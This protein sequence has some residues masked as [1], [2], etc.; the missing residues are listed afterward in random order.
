MNTKL[1]WV[2][3]LAEK[4]LTLEYRDGGVTH[5]SAT[6]DTGR[7]ILSETVTAFIEYDA[8]LQRTG[9]A[10]QLIHANQVFC[11][12]PGQRHQIKNVSGRSG[13]SRWSHISFHLLGNIDVFSLLEP[14]LVVAGHTAG[15]IGE[16][17][18]ALT[19]LHAPGVLS[20]H[21]VAQRQALAMELLAIL[22]EHATVRGGRLPADET[23]V[24][25]LSNVLELISQ[26]L[27]HPP[28]IKQMAHAC[29]LSVSRFH[30]TFK[31]V[32]GA[33]P[34]RYLQDLRLLRARQLLL[35]GDL[36]VK[37]VA[38]ETGFADVFHFSR[39]FRKRC[40]ASPSAYRAQ[41]HRGLM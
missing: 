34:G 29:G 38:A 22:A 21:R 24:Q 41:V 27:S 37:S 4:T 32:M 12:P 25:R 10:D 8:I 15:R 17:N 31:T 39:L 16:I 1:Q 6:H 2:S 13:I 19:A 7:R 36:P 9:C 23:V 3:Q 33:S 20:L 5:V 35:A 14:P 11:V 40:G 30:A 28:D 26:D 18:A